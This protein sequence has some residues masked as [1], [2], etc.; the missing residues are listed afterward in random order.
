M[1][2]PLYNA[3]WA[4]NW[5][6]FFIFMERSSFNCQK[7]FKS[8]SVIWL[9]RMEWKYSKMEIPTPNIFLRGA[10]IFTLKYFLLAKNLLR[11]FQIVFFFHSSI[12]LCFVV[13]SSVCEY[14]G[15]YF[16]AYVA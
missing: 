11:S 3:G 12:S 14:L 13:I 7:N 2:N 9:V 5:S 8:E 10:V 15:K 16:Y 1:K 4:D 6:Y